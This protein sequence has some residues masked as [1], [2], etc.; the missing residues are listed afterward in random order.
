[1]LHRFIAAVYR[2]A[3]SGLDTRS[4]QE[5]SDCL[6]ICSECDSLEPSRGICLECFCFVSLKAAMKTE[7]CPLHKWDR[8]I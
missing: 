2:Y 4:K 8:S 1:M 6:Q 3:A 5:Y 7:Q